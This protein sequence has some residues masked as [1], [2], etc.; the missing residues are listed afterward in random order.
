VKDVK[1]NID[2]YQK[3]EFRTRDQHKVKRQPNWGG[4]IGLFID[5]SLKY[6]ILPESIFIRGVYES[7][8]VKV[9]VGKNKLKIIGNVYRPNG[10]LADLPRALASQ[11]TMIAL[12]KSSPAYKKC[13]IWICGDFNLN[14]LNLEQHGPTKLHYESMLA[15]NFLP[16][17][18]HIL[19]L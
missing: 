12:I 6:D 19:Q 4:G 8:W 9:A 1:F 10:A 17:I 13:E 18:M 3:L 11:E 16:V 7:I 15:R 2:G 14:F 5:A